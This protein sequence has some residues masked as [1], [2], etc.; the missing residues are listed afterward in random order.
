MAETHRFRN[1]VYRCRNQLVEGFRKAASTICVGPEC[2]GFGVNSAHKSS[3]RFCPF[4]L[5]DISGTA[6]FGWEQYSGRKLLELGHFGVYF[7]QRTN[8]HLTHRRQIPTCELHY[9]KFT[10][11]YGQ[12]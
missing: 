3:F 4:Q 6:L 10:A 11:Q 12:D 9:T 8:E 7:E 2:G 5:R 1:T